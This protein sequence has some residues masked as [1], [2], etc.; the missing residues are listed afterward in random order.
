M[1][2]KQAFLLGIVIDLGGLTVHDLR[3]SLAVEAVPEEEKDMAI[4]EGL[5]ELCKENLLMW[6]FEPD[7]GNSECVKPRN[8]GIDLFKE[9]WA[10]HVFSSDL[11]AEVPDSRNPTMFLEG[12]EQLAVELDKDVYAAWRSDL[13]W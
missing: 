3:C 12:S 6:T 1:L 11:S 7:Y 10:K 8:C 5:C 13:D 9:C 4:Y 2:S